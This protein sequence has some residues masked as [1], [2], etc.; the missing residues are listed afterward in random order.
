MEEEEKLDDQQGRPGL[1]PAHWPG[2]EPA[3]W[4]GLEP[5]HWPGLEPELAGLNSSLPIGLYL[6]VETED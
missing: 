2:P 6:R 5:S 4:P 1:E 3:H